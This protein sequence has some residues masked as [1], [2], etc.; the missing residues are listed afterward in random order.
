M[1]Q[2][3][4]P[5]TE[6]SRLQDW[7]LTLEKDEQALRERESQ[8]APLPEARE[9]LMQ[10]YKKVEMYQHLFPEE[11]TVPQNVWQRLWAEPEDPQQLSMRYAALVG[12]LR[13]QFELILQKIGQAHGSWSKVLDELNYRHYL[14]GFLEEQLPAFET[15]IEEHLHPPEDHIQ[16]V[17]PAKQPEEEPSIKV[18]E[19]N[20]PVATLQDVESPI[21]LDES[22]FMSSSQEEASPFGGSDELALSS[23]ALA[24]YEPDKSPG[25]DKRV[26]KRLNYGARVRLGGEEQHSFYTGFTENISTGGLFVATFAISP[27]LGDRLTLHFS[28]PNGRE[29]E[30]ECEVMWLRAFSDEQPLLSPGFGLR[31]LDLSEDDTN[32]ING[33]IQ[34]AG[35]LFYA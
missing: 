30:A 6:T 2:Q 3:I 33:Y 11:F 17:T 10:R 22:D 15:I 28:L 25:E 13:D 26:Y 4:T 29:I 5:Q 8:I 27:D 35:S 1:H 32:A 23:E 34:V 7:L 16:A 18:E 31:F 14:L 9:A 21:E 12:Q 24:Y 19:E 20:S